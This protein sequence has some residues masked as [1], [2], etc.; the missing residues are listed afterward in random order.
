MVEMPRAEDFQ[1]AQAVDATLDA[2]GQPATRP[3]RI[4]VKQGAI[5]LALL[6]GVT[7]AA[8][9]ATTI[10]PTAAISN[11]PTTPM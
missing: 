4:S 1:Q 3:R 10:G 11:R 7:A 6:S 9:L 8:F 2:P 5:A